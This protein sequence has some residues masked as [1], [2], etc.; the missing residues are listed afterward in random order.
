MLKA[1][2]LIMDV[3]KKTPVIVEKDK[4]DL[5]W[6]QLAFLR[7]TLKTNYLTNTN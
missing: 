2:R 6:Y 7:K 1:R 3:E 4:N 5:K